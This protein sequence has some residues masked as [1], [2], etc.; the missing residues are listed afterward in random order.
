MSEQTYS[1]GL[2][3]MA[4]TLTQLIKEGERLKDR[5]LMDGYQ[6]FAEWHDACCEFIEYLQL[7]FRETVNTPLDVEKGLQWLGSTFRQ[8]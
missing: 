7:T 1:R 4:P 3:K 8:T 2:A 5:N 6:R